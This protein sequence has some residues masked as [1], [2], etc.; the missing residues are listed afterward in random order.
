MIIN[1][2]YNFELFKIIKM[3]KPK[4]RTIIPNEIDPLKSKEKT[5]YS[6]SYDING[7]DNKVKFQIRLL[8]AEKSNYEVSGNYLYQIKNSSHFD[9]QAE[10]DFCNSLHFRTIDKNNQE[11]NKTV[12]HTHIEPYQEII[13]KKKKNK[14]LKSS[15]CK[16]QYNRGYN[17]NTRIKFAFTFPSLKKQKSFVLDDHKEIQDNFEAWKKFKPCL[18]EQGLIYEL[19]T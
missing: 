6:E 2:L 5:T 13:R 18:I 19:I 7:F 8:R 15:L 10:L 11:P 1:K 14:D 9:I 4:Y 16:V 12:F 17:I 3:F